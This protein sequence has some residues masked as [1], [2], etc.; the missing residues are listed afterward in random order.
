MELAILFVIVTMIP[1]PLVAQDFKYRGVLYDIL[2]ESEHTVRTNRLNKYIGSTYVNIPAQVYDEKNTEY[3]V[4]EI[5]GS[6]FEQHDSLSI[7]ILPNTIKAIGFGAFYGCGRLEELILPESV[8]TIESYAFLGCRSLEDFVIPPKVTN[9]EIYTFHNCENLRDVTLPPKL[10]NIKDCAFSGCKSLGS[11]EIPNSVHYMGNYVF[12]GCSSLKYIKLSDSLEEIFDHT[13]DG[14]ANLTEV[15]LGVGINGIGSTT[16][17]DC[18]LKILNIGRVIPPTVRGENAFSCY[19]TCELHVPEGAKM[20]YEQAEVWKNFKYIIEDKDESQIELTYKG[21]TY[22]VVDTINN[23]VEI[24]HGKWWHPWNDVSGEIEIPSVIFDGNVQYTVTRIGEAAFDSCENLG[25]VILPNSVKSIAAC[26]FI[27]CINLKEIRLSESL[28]EIEEYAFYGCSSLE[29]ISLPESIVSIGQFAFYDCNKLTEIIIPQNV[30]SIGT[31]AFFMCKNLQ[32]I[33]LGKNLE[34]IEDLAFYNCPIKSILCHQSIPPKIFKTTFS[35]YDTCNL[36]VPYGT[37]GQ[38]EASPW[39]QDFNRITE[40]EQLSIVN[41][42]QAPIKPISIIE[43]YDLNGVKIYEGNS[44]DIDLPK[45]I[46]IKITN[47]KAEKV[48][49]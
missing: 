3:T 10:F 26:A 31:K 7:V 6:T 49:N 33:E 29:D 20:L 45:G 17:K 9:L 42:I 39:W 48:I 15:D 4:T 34:T 28:S 24:K 35:S 14:C 41:D 32:E 44:N 1:S 27:D 25:K 5:G 12:S 22:T 11:I 43:I 30:N 19:E 13:F 2:S 47:G 8:L 40:S 16:F 46:Y 23:Y 18:P 37:K 21:L 38:Y 36:F